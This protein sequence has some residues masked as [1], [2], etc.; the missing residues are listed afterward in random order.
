MLHWVVHTADDTTS[1]IHP[2]DF[3]AGMIRGPA[4]RSE[5]HH[6]PAVDWSSS[7]AIEDRMEVSDMTF[8]MR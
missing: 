8:C 4:G 3:V 6:G 7:L 2:T 5:G 1:R